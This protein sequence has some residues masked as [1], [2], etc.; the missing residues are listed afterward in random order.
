MSVELRGGFVSPDRHGA[1]D[2]GVTVGEGF[3]YDGS[4]STEDVY[5]AEAS[6]AD[7][8]EFALDG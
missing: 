7:G 1:G 8:G 4:H 5:Y 2:I 3:D 6:D